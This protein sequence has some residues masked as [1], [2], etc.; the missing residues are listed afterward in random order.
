MTQALLELGRLTTLGVTVE[1]ERKT[2]STEKQRRGVSETG[3]DGTREESTTPSKKT[4]A[5][6]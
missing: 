2:D 4:L 1:R 5:L 6:L 3:P